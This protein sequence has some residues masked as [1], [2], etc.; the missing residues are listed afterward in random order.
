MLS[1]SLYIVPDW[2]KEHSLQS[3]LLSC[4]SH[5]R[6][7]DCTVWL[8][9]NRTQRPKWASSSPVFLLVRYNPYKNRK[10]Q[11]IFPFL[12]SLPILWKCFQQVWKTCLFESS[13]FVY[14]REKLS[15]VDYSIAF[16][17]LASTSGWN[18]AALLAVYR[19]G[20]NTRL[21]AQLE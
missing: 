3:P 1:A 9:G 21:R 13:Y 10:Q 20:L 16:R 15:V 5:D 6:R 19:H 17:I 12:V 8:R 4:S 18:K 7:Q 11:W 2:N 14:A